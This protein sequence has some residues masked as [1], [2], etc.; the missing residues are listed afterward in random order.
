MPVTHK[1]CGPFNDV[2]VNIDDGDHFVRETA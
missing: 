1:L 2:Y